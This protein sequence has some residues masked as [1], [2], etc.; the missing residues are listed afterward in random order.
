MWWLGAFLF[1]FSLTKT[2]ESVQFLEAS[3]ELLEVASAG[4]SSHE[5]GRRE[6]GIW[7]AL[8]LYIRPGGCAVLGSSGRWGWSREVPPQHN[9]SEIRTMLEIILRQFMK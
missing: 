3:L 8:L 1:L 4:A 5:V 2:V 6:E 7:L 9:H